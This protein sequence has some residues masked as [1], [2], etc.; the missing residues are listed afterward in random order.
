MAEPSCQL[1][2]K[3]QPR[4]SQSRIVGFEGEILKIKVHAP[5]EDGKANEEVIELLHRSLRLPRQKIKI[6]RGEKSRS[7]W[8][9]IQGLNLAEARAAVLSLHK[10]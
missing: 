7:K 10:T 1:G 6:L 9:E 8:V 5:P 4:S 2:I 3:V